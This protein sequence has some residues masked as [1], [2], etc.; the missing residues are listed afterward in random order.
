MA[1]MFSSC[2]K[3]KIKGRAMAHVTSM[4][5]PCATGLT[6]SRHGKTSSPIMSAS[7]ARCVMRGSECGGG[8]LFGV[9]W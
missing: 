9:T 8:L 1:G 7:V 6:C 3:R 4:S 2:D 5:H